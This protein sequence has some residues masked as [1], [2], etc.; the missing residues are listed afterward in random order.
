LDI[1]V[2]NTALRRS[3]L[4]VLAVAMLTLTTA[5][6]LSADAAQTAMC[7]GAADNARLRFEVYQQA[8]PPPRKPRAYAYYPLTAAVS[9]QLN[10]LGAA[11]DGIATWYYHWA[12]RASVPLSADGGRT[13][14]RKLNIQPSLTGKRRQRSSF[15]S[16]ERANACTLAQAASL[17]GQSA[18]G[19]TIAQSAGIT[20]TGEAALPETDPATPIDTCLTASGA[21]PRKASGIVLDYEVQDGRDPATT[22]RF[23]KAYAELVHAAGRH[24]ILLVN[25]LDSPG[26]QKFTGV[27][28]ANASRIVALFDRTLLVVWSGNVE[29]SLADSYAA[30]MAIVRAGGPV[31]TRRLLIDFELAGTT[32][33]DARFVHAAIMRDKLGGVL[34]WR[35][36]AR[37]GGDCNSAVNQR[38]AAVAW[39]TDTSRTDARVQRFAP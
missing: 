8:P 30:Q 11:P 32:I 18:R 21:L 24:A 37:Q 27:V 26:E 17:L 14:V 9:S 16:I 22:E 39:G 25:P 7:F 23:L 3:R 31:D 20:L 12:N 5:G 4:R 35:N 6:P 2:G 10:T 1:A 33:E 19:H 13:I 36:H 34:F 38:I 29:H 28:A 15:S